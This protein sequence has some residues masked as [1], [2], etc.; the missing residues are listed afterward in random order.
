MQNSHLPRTSAAVIA[1][2]AIL[3]TA[4]LVP[5][6]H[7]RQQPQAPPIPAVAPAPPRPAP[8]LFHEAGCEQCH[9]AN[10]AG[11]AKGP[12]L[13]TVGKVLKKDAIR[14]QIHDGGGEMPPFADALEPDEI[15]R[16]VDFLATKKKAPKGLPPTP[17]RVSPA[18]PALPPAPRNS[19]GSDD[20]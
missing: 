2:A 3:L 8:V 18:A 15:D 11:T 17:A 20:Q 4:V 9:G 7:A 14:Q 10:L 16:L 6:L 12:S 19:G 13:L 1:A 5:V